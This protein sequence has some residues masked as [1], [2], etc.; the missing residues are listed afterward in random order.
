MIGDDGKT[1]SR[2]NFA[3]AQFQ[4]VGLSHFM[5]QPPARE[6]RPPLRPS[7]SP[8]RVAPASH[9]SG[10]G[11]TRSH[12][13]PR[14]GHHDAGAG[15]FLD[16]RGGSGATPAV[17]RHGETPAHRSVLHPGRSGRGQ[18]RPQ[19]LLPWSG[20]LR[21]RPREACR[22]Q[23]HGRLGFHRRSPL[24]DRHALRGSQG[25]HRALRR[26]GGFQPRTVGSGDEGAPRGGQRVRP[27]LNQGAKE[28]QACRRSFT[29]HG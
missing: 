29:T 28:G 15:C 14:G 24:S 1:S 22:I 17:V 21:V 13:P 2:K 4:G 18:P 19:P 20:H 16:L 8:L 5:V 27:A 12:R 23:T 3:T 10:C 9:S 6:P 25:D 26:P 7:L 11:P